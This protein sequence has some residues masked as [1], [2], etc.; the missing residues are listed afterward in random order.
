V[1][2]VIK[3]GKITDVIFVR[4]TCHDQRGNDHSSAFPILRQETLAAQKA[5]VSVVGRTTFT[6]LAYIKSVQ[7]ALDAAGFKG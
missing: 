7:S 3:N 1:D 4:A 2:V 6:S 5:N